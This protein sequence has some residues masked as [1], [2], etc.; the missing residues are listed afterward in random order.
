MS[1]IFKEPR[2]WL[3]T[4]T[5][6]EV[7]VAVVA[8]E[9][10]TGWWVFL[11]RSV[12]EGNYALVQVLQGSTLAFVVSWEHQREDEP[13]VGEFLEHIVGKLFHSVH[14]GFVGL[15][16]FDIATDVVDTQVDIYEVWS[17]PYEV[18]DESTL[19]QFVRF[20]SLLLD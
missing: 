20:T 8:D 10:W 1:T 6:L 17:C 12:D 4:F 7:S 11:V 16:V 14:S 5:Q 19:Y 2:L 9:S 18:P 3:T 15:A 13:G